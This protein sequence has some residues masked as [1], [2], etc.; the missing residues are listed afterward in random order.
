MSHFNKKKQSN[1]SANRPTIVVKDVEA[2]PD[3]PI[4]VNTN[5]DESK[6]LLP[7]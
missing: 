2:F 3:K 5:T 6:E 4:N 1:D 7:T